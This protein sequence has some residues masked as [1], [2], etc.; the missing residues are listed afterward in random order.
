MCDV[1]HNNLLLFLP[2]QSLRPKHPSGSD[3][4]RWNLQIAT[5]LQSRG[6]LEPWSG[7]GLLGQDF[8]DFLLGRLV[9][10]V[11][12]FPWAGESLRSSPGRFAGRPIESTFIKPHQLGSV[13]NPLSERGGVWAAVSLVGYFRSFLW[14]ERTGFW[15]RPPSFGFRCWIH[16]LTMWCTHFPVRNQEQARYLKCW[17]VLNLESIVL[18]SWVVDL[19]IWADFFLQQLKSAKIA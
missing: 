4:Q 2:V 1:L 12:P 14:P 8:S 13:P 9:F 7:A 17:S 10:W 6:V 15:G 5:I 11:L 18:N 16:T 19:V 3:L